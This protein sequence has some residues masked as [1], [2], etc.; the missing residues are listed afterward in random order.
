MK[1]PSEFKYFSN[2]LTLIYHVISIIDFENSMKIFCPFV[3]NLFKQDKLILGLKIIEY[4]EHEQQTDF[5]L[6]SDEVLDVN[7][8]MYSNS[9]I[10]SYFI[11]KNIIEILMKFIKENEMTIIIFLS[12][13]Y[14]LMIPKH[15][16]EIKEI[17]SIISTKEMTLNDRSY[18][19]ITKFLKLENEKLLNLNIDRTE[20]LKKLV[21][22]LKLDIPL[23]IFQE[24][25]PVLFDNDYP[26]PLNDDVIFLL[27]SI[28]SSNDIVTDILV[29]SII[30]CIR[31]NS[32]PWMKKIFELYIAELNTIFTDEVD[33][34]PDT[35][36]ELFLTIIRLF[37]VEYEQYI[38]GSNF[39]E[40]IIYYSEVF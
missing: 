29:H 9:K 5:Y 33:E 27:D 4:L 31:Y 30:D 8:Q 17:F 2:Y 36:L 3:L 14:K 1:V 6:E 34:Y 35:L 39:M 23:D 11:D 26:I 38:K 32:K 12:Y 22:C 25:I 13:Y 16:K 15:E 24:L 37:G 10:F 20:N 40:M 28:L 7:Q 19:K 18:L 21:N